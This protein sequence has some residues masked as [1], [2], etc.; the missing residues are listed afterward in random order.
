MSFSMRRSSLPVIGIILALTIAACAP[1]ATP[2]PTTAPSKAPPAVTTAPSAAT[3]APS[4]AVAADPKSSA[5]TSSRASAVAAKLADY[6]QK[7][8]TSGQT[9]VTHYATFGVEADPLIEQ[10][11]KAFPGIEVERV[12]LRTGDD[13]APGGGGQRR[14]P[15]LERR[16]RRRYFHDHDRAG[17]SSTGMGRASKRC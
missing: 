3:A 6:Y 11:Q 7:A 8:L 17:R 2:P 5:P 9:K 10:F 4:A 12:Q 1:M 14:P 13:P 16:Q 15:D